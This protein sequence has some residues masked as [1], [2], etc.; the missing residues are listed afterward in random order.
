MVIKLP[1]LPSYRVE[2]IM[3]MLWGCC[4]HDMTQQLNLYI[5]FYIT[6]AV[7]EEG[8]D[9]YPGSSNVDRAW[10]FTFP[11]CTCDFCCSCFCC[12]LLGLQPQSFKHNFMDWSV[13]VSKLVYLL[14]YFFNRTV[15]QFTL[16][17]NHWVTLKPKNCQNS[18]SVHNAITQH[19][20]QLH[21]SWLY[22]WEQGECIYVFSPQPVLHSKLSLK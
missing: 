15:P 22:G 11:C 13:N 18:F 12:S 10:H 6:A 20:L 7:S 17:Y 8:V 9:G 4:N 2:L 1:Q 14:C 21:R 19:K 16:Q 3:Q 5:K